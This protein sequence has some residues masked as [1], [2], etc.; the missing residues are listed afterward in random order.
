[1]LVH[2]RRRTSRG[3]VKV[4]YGNGVKMPRSARNSKLE[5]RT[6]RLKLPRHKWHQATLEP[7]LALRYRRTAQ[8]YGV[9]YARIE[10]RPTAARIG[11]ADDYSEAD[12]ET[13]FD[14]KQA[15]GEA[16]KLAER[17]PAPSYTVK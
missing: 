10:G 15:Q 6:A 3:N 7:G 8:G 11:V 12:G 17:G 16:R 13:V 5:T 2:A 4:T 1:M 9:W 14:W